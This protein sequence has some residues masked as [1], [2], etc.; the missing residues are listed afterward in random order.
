MSTYVHRIRVRYGECDMQKVVFNAN[1]LAYCDDAAE[2]W[3]RSK[4]ASIHDVGWDFMLKKSVIE[5]SGAAGY[6]DEIDI[7]VEATRWGNTSFDVT[8][9][10][11]VGERPIFTNVIT[12][13]G[14]KLGT[15]ETM[16][17]PEEVKAALSA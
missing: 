14:V 7:A 15:L 13:V 4:G 6:P 9:S 17:P 10:G 12:Y 1:Y 5:W 8:F 16:P 3:V 2:G 11:T